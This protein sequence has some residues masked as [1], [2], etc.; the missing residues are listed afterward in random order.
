MQF[1]SGHY[2]KDLIALER[3]RKRF[4]RML[5]GFADFNDEDIWDGLD[6]I[7]S[8]SRRLREKII[9]VYKFKK[10]HRQGR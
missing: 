10:V 2:R 8:K 5:A 3:V 4:T 6:L 1:W 7:S 9:N